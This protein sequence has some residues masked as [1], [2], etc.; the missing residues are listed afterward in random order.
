MNPQSRSCLVEFSGAS[1]RFGEILALDNLD[2]RVCPGE[3]LAIL[4][5]N[6][7]S[8]RRDQAEE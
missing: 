4:G 8:T 3:L 1:K 5:P 7:A 6:G 2:L